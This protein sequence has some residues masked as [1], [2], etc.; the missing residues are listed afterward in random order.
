MTTKSNSERPAGGASGPGAAGFTAHAGAS[1]ARGATGNAS[2][3]VAIVAMTAPRIVPYF[4]ATTWRA[5]VPGQQS[6]LTVPAFWN[7]APSRS[8]MS[9]L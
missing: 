4:V 1:A 6:S 8:A 3:A 2:R 7:A 9:L 5:C